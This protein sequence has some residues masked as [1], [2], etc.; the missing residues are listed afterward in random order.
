MNKSGFSIYTIFTVI[1]I[2]MFIISIAIF[3]ISTILSLI[4]ILITATMFAVI[5]VL[6]KNYKN[7]IF[8]V[9]ENVKKLVDGKSEDLLDGIPA[10]LAVVLYDNSDEII[11]Y[12]A[13]FK[14]SFIECGTVNNNLLSSFISEHTV[15]GILS[16]DG[17]DVSC[18]DKKFK[19]FAKKIDDFVVL[20]FIDNT[21]CRNI[22]QKY[23]DSRPCVGLVLFDNKEELRQS[24]SDEQNLQISISVENM[25]NKWVNEAEGM[26]KKLG[27]G[28]YL[29][30]FAEKYLK[31]FS[32]EKFKIIDNIHDA[33]IDDHTYATIS[34]GISLG[35]KSFEEA[36]TWSEN[37]LNMALGRGGDQVAVK[38]NNSYEFFG[39][40][41][42]GLEKR[43]KVRTRVVANAL[44]E[45]IQSSDSVFIMGHKF[46]DFDSIGAAAGLWSVC[47]RVKKKNAYIVVNKNNSLAGLAINHLEKTGSDKMFIS[48]EQA[49]PLITEKSLLIVVDTHFLKSLESVDVY[50]MFKRVTVIDHHRMTVD[51]INNAVIFYHEPSA[52]SACEMVTELIQYMGDAGLKK[53]EAEC[54]L[55]G[56]MLDTKN[57]S[58]KSGVRTFEAAAYLKRKGADNAEVK[59]MFVNSMD[60]YKIKCRIIESARMVDDCAIARLSEREKDAR[61]PCAQAADELLNVKNVRASFVIFP[62][63]DG[64]SISARSFGDVNVQI[65]MEALG[66]GGHQ[67]MAAAQIPNMSFEQAEEKLIKI[68]KEKLS[69]TKNRTENRV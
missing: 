12:N 62:D 39:G 63:G 59:K 9:S 50:K 8:G 69:D 58:L 23:I 48:P 41:S 46:S 19:V 25:L 51:K 37:A 20:Y 18:N 30:V 2:I 28:K 32:V 11:F 13:A 16:K 38:N 67:T 27:D 60:A 31:N 68:I 3:P 22:K 14:E 55:A 61:V 4:S 26:L 44:L 45:K 15:D 6:I 54:L 29:V 52:S 64:V 57:F 33:K 40:K 56:I 65:I 10:P 1:A 17:A 7:Y 21:E 43:S 49:K 42:Q 47:T 36:K 5:F 53:A 35:A 24:L 66:G 34:M